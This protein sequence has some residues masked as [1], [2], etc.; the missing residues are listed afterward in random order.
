MAS[1]LFDQGGGGEHAT[2]GVATKAPNP[3]ILLH[4]NFLLLLPYLTPR[5]HSPP[6]AKWQNVLRRPCRD[7]YHSRHHHHLRLNQTLHQ[8][9]SLS[10]NEP[11][12]HSTCHFQKSSKPKNID[13]KYNN[14]VK[15]NKNKKHQH[16]ETNRVSPLCS[17]PFLPPAQKEPKMRE[18]PELSAR[19]T[20]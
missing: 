2:A 17:L 14:T 18:I 8:Q 12:G 13:T 16:Y 9:V 10:S 15:K 11:V 19:C 4:H 1:R 3:T 5:P 20:E 7:S 6:P